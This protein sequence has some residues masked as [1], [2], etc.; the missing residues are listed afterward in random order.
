MTMRSLMYVGPRQVEWQEAVAPRLQGDREAL[1]RPLAVTRCDLDY[2]IIHGATGWPGPFALGHEAVGV[3]TDVGNSVSNFRPG[4]RVIVPFQLSCG[5]C[6]RCRA[7]LTG[8]CTTVPFRSSYGMAPLSGVEHGGA[9][10]D[11]MRVPFADHMLVACPEEISHVAAAGIADNV[12][13]AYRSIAPYLEVRPGARVL[14]VGGM[15][16]GIG[17]YVA[18][19]AKALG[20]KE[21]VYLDDQPARLELARTLGVRVLERLSWEGAAPGAPYPITIDASGKAEGLGLAIRSTEH[22]GVVHRS[23]GDLVPQ[24]LVPLRDMYGIGMTLHLSRVHARTVMPMVTEHV[25]CGHL[26]PEHII[27]RQVG[28]ADAAEAIFDPAIKVV[29]VAD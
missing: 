22:G 13:D 6:E 18:Q 4:D 5:A 8:I 17:L 7:G 19:T 15:G 2:S 24:T 11:L 23:H 21:V 16:Q 14:I 27:T 10:S 26:H 3:V 28:F 29:F 12:T 9:L 20:A 25:R 1:V